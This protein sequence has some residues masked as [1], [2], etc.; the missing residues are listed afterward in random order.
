MNYYCLAIADCF[1]LLDSMFK[2]LF[3]DYTQMETTSGVFATTTLVVL[4]S[5]G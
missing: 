1:F 3:D 2:L 5:L 4:L